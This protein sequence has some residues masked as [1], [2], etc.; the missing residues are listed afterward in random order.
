[1]PASGSGSTS[2]RYQPDLVHAYAELYRGSAY[3]LRS[4]ADD[5]ARRVRPLLRRHRL[6]GSGL[7]RSPPPGPAVRVEPQATPT[8]F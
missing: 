7:L 5:L 1:M 6:D 8:L 2:Q 3:V 4:Y